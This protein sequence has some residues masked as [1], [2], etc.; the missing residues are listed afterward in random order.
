MTEQELDNVAYVREVHDKGLAFDLG[1][2]S[3][4]RMLT[5]IGGAGAAVMVTGTLIGTAG[6]AAAALEEIE[7]ETAGPYPADGSN[8]I[9]VRTESGI[10]RSDI[11]SS[12]G[13][14]TTTAEGIPLTF[15]ITVVDLADAPI[16]GAAVYAWHCDRD[17]NYSLYS[18]GIT[19]ENYLRGI[20]ETDSTGTVTFT[21]IFPA[22][23]SGRWPHIHFEVYSSL[24]NAT[25]GAGP[26]VKTSQIAI[27]EEVADLVYATDGYSRSV[28]N[29][30]QV[31]LATDNVFGDDSA[32]REL[33][34]VTGSV[35]A[36]FVA[37][38]TAAVDPSGTEESGGTPPSGAPPSGAPSAPPSA[39]ASTS[40]A[41]STSPSAT[42]STTAAAPGPQPRQRPRK[43]ERHWWNP[44]T[45]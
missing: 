9:D 19:G 2:M 25:S 45:W 37:R 38:L 11:R 36:G 17:G 42:A 5:L 20:Q 1:T 7:S 41:A 18:T 26:I 33:A 29:L 12:F 28:T 27:P 6:P 43:K 4:R 21:S 14:S 15:S 24:A 13:T 32:A 30:S 34:T 23:Y 35:E 39:S 8:G 10:V 40:T 31:S 44:F 3:R 16:V 22:C